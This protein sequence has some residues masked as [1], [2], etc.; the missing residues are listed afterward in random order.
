I[1]SKAPSASPTCQFEPAGSSCDDHN[2]TT[3]SDQC[4]S[5]GICTGHPGPLNPPDILDANPT[6]GGGSPGGGGHDSVTVT[7][8]DESDGEDGFHVEPADVPCESA[9]GVRFSSV[10]RVA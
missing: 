7:F 4:N 9:D 6:P 10:G 3:G 5:V 8:I 1:Q 2:P